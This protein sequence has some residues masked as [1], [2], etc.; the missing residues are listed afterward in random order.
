MKKLKK[1][2]GDLSV[3]M[4]GAILGSLWITHNDNWKYYL[5]ICLIC[6]VFN[7]YFNEN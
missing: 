1:V 5:P 3:L 4:S 2:V 6:I 7:Q